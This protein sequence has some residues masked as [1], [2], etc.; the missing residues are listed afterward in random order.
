MTD[1]TADDFRRGI[2]IIE[3]EQV[4]DTTVKFSMVR[5]KSFATWICPATSSGMGK[6]PLSRP[7]PHLMGVLG[8]PTKSMQGRKRSVRMEDGTLERQKVV[9]CG[10][11]N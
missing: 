10:N 4:A 9:S 8:L 2:G 11:K 5:P 7:K 6:T 1:E 3:E